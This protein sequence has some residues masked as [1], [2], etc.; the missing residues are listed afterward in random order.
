MKTGA[1]RLRLNMA[2]AGVMLSTCVVSAQQQVHPVEPAARRESAGTGRRATTAV[3]SLINGVAVDSHQKPVPKARLRLRNLELNAIE[4]NATAN[5]GGEFSFAARPNVPY[6][7]EIADHA[8]RV[9]AVSD[10]IVAHEGEV[11]GGKVALPSHVP[12]NSA[13]FEETASTVI[14]AATSAGIA[15]VNPELPTL[16][17]R[18]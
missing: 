16:S 10:V 18:Q 17:P 11:V 14:S 4:Q 12:P 8:G 5:N 13:T 7:V 2:L 15:V 6:V 3:K 9:I 1:M